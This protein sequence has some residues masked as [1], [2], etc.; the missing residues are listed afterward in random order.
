MVEGG[1]HCVREPGGGGG[2]AHIWDWSSEGVVE[3]KGRGA[4]VPSARFRRSMRQPF[5]ARKGC[6]TSSVKRRAWMILYSGAKTCFGSVF[7]RLAYSERL[8]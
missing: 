7:M 6:R 8:M 3:R 1:C 2:K 4:L 5:K